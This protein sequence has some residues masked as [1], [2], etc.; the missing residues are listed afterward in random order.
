M[1]VVRMLMLG[2]V[3]LMV[4]AACGGDGGP[5]LD[6][7]VLQLSIT[8][9]I[10]GPTR[11]EMIGGRGAAATNSTVECRMTT[12][13]EPVIGQA[14]A[15]QFGAFTMPLD[16]T[17]FPAQPPT[18]DEYKTFNETVECHVEDGP[19]V[20]PLKQPVIRIG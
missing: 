11:A 1:R 6:D 17:A 3:T 20:S 7:R 5:K 9:S 2:M 16:Q 13:D 19:W 15:D 12:G 18:A 14:T 10:N 4:I 8:Y